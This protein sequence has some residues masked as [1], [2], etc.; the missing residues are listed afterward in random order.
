[1]AWPS[2]DTALNIH[3]IH[4]A[5]DAEPTAAATPQ[6]TSD[7]T[8]TAV[9]GMKKL[10]DP[11]DTHHL[12]PTDNRD[13]IIRQIV[14][15]LIGAETPNPLLIGGNGTGK[16]HIVRELARRLAANDKR[17][18]RQLRGFTIWALSL[19]ILIAGAEGSN[20]VEARVN[21]VKNFACDPKNHCI[22]FIDEVHQLAENGQPYAKVA[23]MLKPAMGD[24]TLRVI[25]AT[26][27][28]EQKR[29]MADGAFA[30]RW[31]KVI[32][33]E[34]TREQTIDVLKSTVNRMTAHYNERIVV[35]DDMLEAIVETADKYA[36]PSQHRPA[37]A[38]KLL[39]R[40]LGA[41]IEAFY[42]ENDGA[43]MQ[44]L[45]ITADDVAKTAAIMS[46]GHAEQKTWTKSTM[47]ERFAGVYDQD[48]AINTIIDTLAVGQ[49]KLFERTHPLSMV[50]VGPTGSGKTTI[51]H[52]IADIMSS[53]DVIEINLAEYTDA[54]TLTI[55]KGSPPGYVGSTSKRE[56]PFDELESNPRQT[57]LLE[58]LDK[59]HPS[60]QNMFVSVLE[61]GTLS[62]N[63]GR[64]IGFKN[65]TVIAT[66]TRSKDDHV[67]FGFDQD[68][69][70]TKNADRDVRKCIPQQLVGK[71]D[72]IV[73]LKGIDK[74]TYQKILTTTWSQEVRHAKH[75]TEKA[76]RIPDTIDEK[77]LDAMVRDSWD[78]KRGGNPARRIVQD[79]IAKRVAESHM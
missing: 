16:T 60:V 46:T 77:T 68:D 14:S 20:G 15:V 23:E 37:T 25:G 52:A 43:P 40:T 51:A 64:I 2:Q 10:Y 35:S 1:M 5:N 49:S 36:T 70:P 76:A 7:E 29:L 47:R 79:I 45:R 59:A 28:Q 73:A 19:D 26:T 71:F 6:T 41:K 39:D 12:A 55:F 42:R 34:F 44:E 48:D 61:N 50:L 3:V 66:V 18:P 13:A 22:L 62:L 69:E 75:A 32:V 38:I 65:A 33:D 63:D 4:T 27:I 9:K 8:A 72:R 56:L 78:E 30:R 17:I 11:D 58:N 74:K 67:P 53:G 24:N 21:A 31:S 54:I 57:V